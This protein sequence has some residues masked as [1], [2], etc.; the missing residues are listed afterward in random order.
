MEYWEDYN[1]EKERKTF[2]QLLMAHSGRL[3][4]AV[5]VLVALFSV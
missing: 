4:F 5:P 1:K 3:L 2:R